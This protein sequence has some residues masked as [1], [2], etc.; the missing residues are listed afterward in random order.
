MPRRKDDMSWENDRAI[1]RMY[2]PALVTDP[3]EGMVSGGLDVWVKR[4]REM[5]SQKWYQDEFDGFMK[6]DNRLPFNSAD[7]GHAA[8]SSGNFNNGYSLY[9]SKENKETIFFPACGFRNSGSLSSTQTS[10]YY[11]TAVLLNYDTG[12]SGGGMFRVLGKS[13]DSRNG[14]DLKGGYFLNGF[15]IRPIKE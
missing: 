10:G 7:D 6:G 12:G 8:N 5:V 15:S 2:G 11:W 13:G 3:D 4:T 1:Y 9:T 14:V